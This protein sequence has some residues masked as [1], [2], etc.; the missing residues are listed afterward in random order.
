MFILLFYYITSLSKKIAFLILL[1][2]Q[3]DILDIELIEKNLN[4]QFFS[5]CLTRFIA[6][7]EDWNQLIN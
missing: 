6:M 1:I 4:P 5:N 7:R 3:N 2:L